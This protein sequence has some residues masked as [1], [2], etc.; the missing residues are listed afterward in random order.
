MENCGN[1]TFKLGRAARYDRGHR[2]RECPRSQSSPESDVPLIL[3]PFRENGS[4]C[5]SHIGREKKKVP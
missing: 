4:W 1:P 2:A 5:G 3:W